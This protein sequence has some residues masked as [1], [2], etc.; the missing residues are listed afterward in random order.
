MGQRVTRGFVGTL[1]FV[2]FQQIISI[3]L[4]SDFSLGELHAQ[5]L[6]RL[7]DA[8][9]DNSLRQIIHPKCFLSMS[10][11]PPEGGAISTTYPL[12]KTI[13]ADSTV[14][15]TLFEGTYFNSS[16]NVSEPIHIWS[17]YVPKEDSTC[18]KV[19][20]LFASMISASIG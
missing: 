16:D 5:A 20:L 4:F 2:V 17:S 3:G 18:S 1:L 12:T 10:F 9:D 13:R 15:Q 8:I 19:P 14:P 7:S 11:F 6:P